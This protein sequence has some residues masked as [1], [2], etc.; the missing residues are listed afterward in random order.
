MNAARRRRSLLS[1]FS[2]RPARTLGR[3]AICVTALTLLSGCAADWGFGSN[4]SASGTVTLTYA[5]WDPHEQVGYQQS[6]DLFEKMH[7][8]IKVNIE[9]IPYGSYEQK[10]IAEFITGGAPDLFWV[11]TPWLATFIKDG[12]L[13]NLTPLIKSSHIDMSQYYPQ[14]VSLHSVGSAIYGLPKDWDTIA[15]YYNKAYFAKLHLTVP[16]NLSWN[17]DGTGSF[18]NFL[19]EATTDTS[20]HNALSPQFNPGKI[21]TYAIGIDNDPQGGWGDYVAEAGGKVLP[22]PNA[23][24]T[25]LDTP[26]V[27]EG[28]TFLT[29][30]LTGDHVMV[31]GSL[32]GPNGNG[33]NLE[34][35]FSEG[36][37]AMWEQGD[38]NT[39]SV[40]SSV[41]FPVGVATLPIGP[42]G[43][44]SV[45][46]GLI[47]GLNAHTPYPKQAWELEQW[48]GS[49][50][51]EAILGSGG[52]VWPAI[53]S[54]DP[55]FLSYWQ[56]QG[57]DMQAFLTE[58][59]GKV[60]NFPNSPGIGDA[61]TEIVNDLGPAY[62]GTEPVGQALKSAQTDAD[63]VLRTS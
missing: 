48:L 37:V 45:F 39:L 26:A 52:Y 56:K 57:I 5:L 27:N 3:V 61:L 42:D 18:V 62:L 6:I 14:L 54:L 19:K 34:Q 31:P 15:L 33:N 40:K 63:Y 10:I 25:T 22:Y 23:S 58:A 53:K 47:D 2:A 43:R 32:S 24:Y 49:P 50:Q 20:G 55:L 28:I 8:N 7:P 1:R 41:T 36:Q 12:I 21:A 4:G 11:N 38:W 16:A 60:V 59:Q 35:M 46:N 51:S 29:K 13:T 44:V 9:N 17:A 30:Y